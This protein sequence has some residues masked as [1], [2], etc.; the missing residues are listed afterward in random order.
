MY[1]KT[2]T[3]GARAGKTWRRWARPWAARSASYGVIGWRVFPQVLPQLL[4]KVRVPQ[5]ESP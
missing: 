2:P 1:I 5:Q 4:L 3:R